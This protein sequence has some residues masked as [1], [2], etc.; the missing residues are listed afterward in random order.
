MPDHH[1]QTPIRVAWTSLSQDGGRHPAIECPGIEFVAVTYHQ[2]IGSHAL[3]R[4]CRIA[5]IDVV[6]PS[7]AIAQSLN[8]LYSSWPLPTIVRIP[9]NLSAL[10]P[11]ARP[12]DEI[13]LPAEPADFFRHRVNRILHGTNLDPLTGLF[14][15]GAFDRHMDLA[16][17]SADPRYPLSLVYFDVDHLKRINDQLG[18]SVGDQVLRQCGRL[19]PSD[20]GLIAGRVGGDE[21]ALLLA[22]VDETAA[23]D[24]AGRLREIIEKQYLDSHGVDSGPVSFTASLG[25]AT[26]EQ[27]IAAN[28]LDEQANTALYAAKAGGR[29]QVVHFRDLERQSGGDVRIQ[30]L[31]LMERVVN[32]RVTE[33]LSRRRRELLDALQHRADRDELTGLF[34]R[35]YLDRRIVHDHREARGTSRPLCVAM[36]DIDHFGTINKRP[37]L[38][39]TGDYAMR[40]LADLIRR[41]VRVTDWVAKYGGDEFAEVFP[42]TTLEIATAIVERIRQT[43]AAHSFRDATESGASYSLT[44]STGVAELQPNEVLTDLWQRLCGKLKS[45]KDSGRNQSQ[46]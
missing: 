24:Y 39:R 13:C 35:G 23:R 5:L 26:T 11:V 32:E 37:G 41:H 9:A 10:I 21:F 6:K 42:E 46:T 15:R 2:L 29:D 19:L 16:L 1:P 38:W 7:P 45:A 14:H 34:N 22:D 8:A 17:R 25:V 31:E 44:V 40:E 12:T 4:D 36:I 3:R 28:E 18:Y 20:R 30:S 33:Y 43:I 27:P